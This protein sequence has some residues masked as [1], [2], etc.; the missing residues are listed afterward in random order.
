MAELLAHSVRRGVPR[1]PIPIPGCRFVR[2]YQLMCTGYRRD[3]FRHALQH[4]CAQVLTTAPITSPPTGAWPCSSCG[5][6]GDRCALALACKCSPRRQGTHGH[7]M[8]ML[9]VWLRGELWDQHGAPLAL[10]LGLGSVWGTLGSTRR[11]LGSATGAGL[12]GELWVRARAPCPS[13]DCMYPRLWTGVGA[14]R[15]WRRAVPVW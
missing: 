8:A 2:V 11:S 12:C 14:L 1:S 15:T 13:Q 9:L 10:P 4:V 3:A 5:S 7:L 6:V